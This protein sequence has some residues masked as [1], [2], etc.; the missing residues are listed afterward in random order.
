MDF[1]I[2]NPPNAKRK[3]TI[4]LDGHSSIHFRRKQSFL[5]QLDDPKESTVAKLATLQKLSD[6]EE[7][8]RTVEFVPTDILE[9]VKQMQRINHRQTVET[10]AKG[11]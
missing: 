9:A 7:L 5:K 3:T 2:I 4:R 1:F 10:I 8:L 6:Y 11:E